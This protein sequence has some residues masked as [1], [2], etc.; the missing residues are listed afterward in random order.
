MK[1][2]K[3]KGRWKEEGKS[4]GKDKRRVKGRRGARN[5]K[6]GGGEEGKRRR[7]QTERRGEEWRERQ[8][9]FKKDQKT[10]IVCFDISSFT[11]LRKCCKCRTYN[12]HPQSSPLSPPSPHLLP[13]LQEEAHCHTALPLPLCLLLLLLPFFSAG[14]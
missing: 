1:G 9:K 12:L 2:R 11:L 10:R 8:M 14:H 5:L 3:K 7:K 13:L 4:G 6:E